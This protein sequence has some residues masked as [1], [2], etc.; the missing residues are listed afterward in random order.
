MTKKSIFKG[1]LV[2]VCF[3]LTSCRAAYIQSKAE[4]TAKIVRVGEPGQLISADVKEGAE[5]VVEDVIDLRGGNAKLPADVSITFKKGGAIVNGTL[6]GN[7][8]RINSR[9]ENVLGVKLK[10]TWCVDK[11]SD[12]AFNSEY[13]S[14]NEVVNNLS[15]IQSDALFNKISIDKDYHITITKSG[16]S[17]LLLSSHSY[18]LLN[19]TLYLNGNNYK[20]YQIIDVQKKE[21]VTIKGGKIVGDVGKHTYVDGSTSEW[22]MGIN[23]IESKDIFVEDV[24]ITHC[25]GDGMYI[26]G[27]NEPTINVYDHA[28]KNVVVRNVVCDDNRRQGLSIIHVD[29]LII[30]GCKFINTGKTE[31]TRPSSGIDFEPNVFNGRNLSIRNVAISNCE[32]SGNKM[33]QIGSYNAFFDGCHSSFENIKIE[34]TTVKGMCY[35]AGDMSFFNCKFGGVTVRNSEMPVHAYFNNCIVSDGDGVCIVVQKPTIK[36]MD[37]EKNRDY[38]VVFDNCE[39][40]LNATHYDENFKG[41]FYYKGS[42]DIY[43]GGLQLRG[44]N[45]TLPQDLHPDMHLFWRPITGNV[46]I[47]HSTVNAMNRPLD[48]AGATYNDCVI[49]CEYLLMNT[50]QHGKD[51]LRN[52]TVNTTSSK[53]ILFL[54][55]YGFTGDGYEIVG[56]HFTNAEATAIAV[57]EKAKVRSKAVVKDNFFA[58][59]NTSI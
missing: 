43:D 34:D 35:I 54:G 20:S 56:C 46:I 1:Y 8:T 5:L 19:G 53:Q 28:S 41:L 31:Y 47:D 55:N 2:I 18:L 15:T 21:N 39:I 38:S 50:V 51:I 17:G 33:K 16:G 44:C 40:T 45:I 25:T 11:I 37:Y 32:V 58:N 48:L 23:I 14:D 49:N 9:Q 3:L 10:G 22:G 42:N 6:T 52:C 26:S 59:N 36:Y 7:G 12:L 30:I 29:G 4:T 13:L 57:E 24:T 27:G